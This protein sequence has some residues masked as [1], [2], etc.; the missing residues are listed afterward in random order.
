ML[1]KFRPSLVALA[2]MFCLPIGASGQAVK[3]RETLPA[4]ELSSRRIADFWTF[5]C[6][7][8]GSASISID[9]VARAGSATS[10][11]DLAFF[12]FFDSLFPILANGDDELPCTV[13]SVCGFS[14]P[15]K[16]FNCGSG[17]EHT[18]MVL[19][20][21]SGGS[22]G[23]GQAEGIY[24]IAVAVFAGP[25]GTGSSLPADQVRL[26]GEEPRRGFPWG[27]IPPG[28]AADDASFDE[29]STP[30]SPGSLVPDSETWDAWGNDALGVSIFDKPIPE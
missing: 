11:F 24:E 10:P 6:P 22:A 13:A 21:V 20:Y 26:G 8:G 1:W 18:I 4:Q 29:N 2:I 9:T 3:R 19:T 15:Q 12:V 25:N 16:L 27:Y 23:C 17:G 30:L 5:Q 14:C 28:P 7:A